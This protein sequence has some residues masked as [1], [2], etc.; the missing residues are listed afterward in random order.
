[1]VIRKE[2]KNATFEYD[3]EKKIFTIMEADGFNGYIELNKIY[4]FSF[5]RFVIR[6]AQRNWLKSA[7]SFNKTEELLDSI[8]EEE[9]DPNQLELFN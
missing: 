8:E 6:M 3:E 2:L 9:D 7:D 1:M 4:A 5:M